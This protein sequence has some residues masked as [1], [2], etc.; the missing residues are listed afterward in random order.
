M[1]GN[2]KKYPVLYYNLEDA[3]DFTPDFLMNVGKQLS[4]YFKRDNVPFIML[5]KV[6][7]LQWITK[8]DAIEQL[9]EM[10]NEV[11]TWE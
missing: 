8:E 7:N 10:L 9:E 1:E 5:P 3:D 6:T 4:E 2:E 11:K